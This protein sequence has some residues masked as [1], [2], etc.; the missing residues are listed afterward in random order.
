MVQITEEQGEVKINLRVIKC[1]EHVSY[2]SEQLFQTV[3]LST[4]CSRVLRF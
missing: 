4:E 2:T 3:S 1:S